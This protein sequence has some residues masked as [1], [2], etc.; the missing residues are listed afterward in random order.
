MIAS[1]CESLSKFYQSTCELFTPSYLNAY[2]ANGAVIAARFGDTER[3]EQ[4]K[5]VLDDAS[6]LEDGYLDEASR[7]A[8]SWKPFLN[9]EKLP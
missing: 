9:S 4:T 3:D 8:L 2:I 6:L 5:A 1:R 7:E